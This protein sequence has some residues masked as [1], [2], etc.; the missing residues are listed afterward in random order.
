MVLD[1]CNKWGKHL[2]PFSMCISALAA[3]VIADKCLC[4]AGANEA[5]FLQLV[6]NIKAAHAQPVNL[7]SIDADGSIY[8]AGRDAAIVWYS[9]R[10]NTDSQVLSTICPD[11]VGIP[12][13]GEM[14]FCMVT[15][16]GL[17][18]IGSIW[19]N[20]ATVSTRHFENSFGVQG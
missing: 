16:S 19:G 18:R 1:I 12:T 5:P 6:A 13:D 11:F 9:F 2:K 3:V 15:S 8:S 7:V 20:F 10:K 4:F 14:L 17:L